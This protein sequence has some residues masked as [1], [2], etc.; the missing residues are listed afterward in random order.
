MNGHKGGSDIQIREECH[1]SVRDVGGRNGTTFLVTRLWF[2]P[3]FGELIAVHGRLIERVYKTLSK[4]K[5]D[6]IPPA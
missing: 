4:K 1:S 2:G 3:T 5:Y 6:H